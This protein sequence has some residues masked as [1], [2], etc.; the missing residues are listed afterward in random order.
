MQ[1]DTA[2]NIINNTLGVPIVIDYMSLD[3]EGAEIEA[4]QSINFNLIDIRFM[5]IEHGN[6][7]GYKNIFADYLKQ[8]G[9]NVH[10]INEWDIEFTK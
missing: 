9:Y 5:T 3:I 7:K 10:R 6:R 2:T 8:F 4:L 1:S